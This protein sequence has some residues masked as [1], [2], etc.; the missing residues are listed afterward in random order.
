[1]YFGFFLSFILFAQRVNAEEEIDVEPKKEEPAA[2]APV[3]E[4][5]GVVEEQPAVEPEVTPVQETP[6]QVRCGIWCTYFTACK[7][8]IYMYFL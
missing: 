4:E 7:G 1:M 5:I 2:V 6:V 3:I 8:A